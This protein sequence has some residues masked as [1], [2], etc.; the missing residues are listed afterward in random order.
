MTGAFP[1]TLAH[2]PGTRMSVHVTWLTFEQLKVGVG[3]AV[4][5]EG[6]SDTRTHKYAHTHM[7]FSQA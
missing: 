6:H 2:S 1:A 3:G 7:H 4:C 5:L